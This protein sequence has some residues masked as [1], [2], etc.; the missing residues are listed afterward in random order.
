MK[1]NQKLLITIGLG[2]LILMNVFVFGWVITDFFSGP[3]GPEETIATTEDWENTTDAEPTTEEIPTAALLPEIEQEFT[4]VRQPVYNRY[5]G[6]GKDEIGYSVDE[7]G[8]WKAL[9]AFRMI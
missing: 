4:E 5:V 9:T 6:S 1:Q 7:D 2:L 8:I 3:Y